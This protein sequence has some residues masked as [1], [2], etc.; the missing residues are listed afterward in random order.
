MSE[1]IGEQGLDGLWEKGG[2]GG[3]GVEGVVCVCS[4]KKNIGAG[5]LDAKRWSRGRG[6][7]FWNPVLTPSLPPSFSYVGVCVWVGV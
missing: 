5:L 3:G 6:S 7:S 1:G 2:R 4:D